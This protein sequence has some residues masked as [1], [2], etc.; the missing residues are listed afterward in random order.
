MKNHS[1]LITHVDLQVPN[2]GTCF[3]Y[4]ITNTGD[5]FIHV[6][7]AYTRCPIYQATTGFKYIQ[8]STCNKSIIMPID[9]LVAFNFK[10]PEYLMM[11]QEEQKILNV[12]HIDNN[13]RNNSAYNLTWMVDNE[14]W[15]PII[16][17]DVKPDMYEISSFGHVRN[18]HTKRI[19]SSF[20]CRGYS[21]IN[22]QDHIL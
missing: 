12:H 15:K 19:L 1:N 16:D 6:D 21:V 11:Q 4:V 9:V 5:I 22:L 18:I 20:N 2:I 10:Q 8:I 17:D 13:S 14:I 3:P 7:G